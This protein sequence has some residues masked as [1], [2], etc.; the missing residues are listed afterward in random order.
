MQPRIPRPAFWFAGSGMVAWI[1]LHRNASRTF[2]VEYAL[3]ANIRSGLVLGMPP[4]LLM[5]QMSAISPV[6]APESCRCPA[7][8]TRGMDAAPRSGE[9]IDTFAGQVFASLPR[10]VQRAT[11][12]LYLRG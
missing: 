4:F 10:S 3:S 9:K 6:K 8:V 12:R 2:W 5:I 1:P 11:G 7:V